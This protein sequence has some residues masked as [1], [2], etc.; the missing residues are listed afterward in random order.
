MAAPGPAL[1]GHT[2]LASLSA[3]WLLLALMDQWRKTAVRAPASLACLIFCFVRGDASRLCSLRDGHTTS[4]RN[5]S[6]GGGE[7]RVEAYAEY[8]AD[9]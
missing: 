9:N 6:L 3:W 8:R 7:R 1:G 5:R 2:A 4:G